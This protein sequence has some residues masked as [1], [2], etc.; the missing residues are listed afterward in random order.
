MD[1][2]DRYLTAVAAQLPVNEREDIVAEL[3]DLILSRFEDRESEL[4]RALTDDEKEAILREIGHPLVVAARYRKGPD[5]LVGP[6][7]FPYWLFGVKAGLLLML[8]IQGVVLLINLVS[9][10]SEGG[11]L[12]AQA[13]HGFFGSALTL[14]GAAT[15]TA[16]IFEHYGVRPK[17][18][19]QWRVKDLGAFGLSDPAAWGASMSSSQGAKSAWAAPRA[20][21][22]P[23]WPGGEYLFSF[24]AVGV[25]VLWWVGVLRFPGLLHIELRGEDAV[26]SGAPIWAVLYGP[27]LLYA[28][29]QMAVDL[30]SLAR[31]YA[32]RMRAA[33]QIV[34]AGVGFWLAWTLFQ[35]GHWLTLSAHGETARVGGDWSLVNFESLQRFNAVGRDLEAVA[36]LL[37]VIFTWMLVAM[38]IG[39]VFKA[40]TNLFRLA[41]PERRP[42]IA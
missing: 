31:P 17:F 38:M 5:S 11:Q 35:A 3:R 19:T 39:M 27:I 20:P 12:V 13:F 23:H 36:G 6:E 16:A 7:L 2:I 34:I 1:L 25:F 41:Q 29:A 8:A 26:V 40:L 24:L 32:V 15:L 30:A 18:L 14:I 21:K 9:G 28:I 33:A 42:Q 10:P 22:A 4:G 37:S